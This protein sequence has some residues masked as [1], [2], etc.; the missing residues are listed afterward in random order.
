MRTDWSGR[1]WR[2]RKDAETLLKKIQIEKVMGSNPNSWNN[3]FKPWSLCKSVQLYPLAIEVVQFTHESTLCIQ[4]T[5]GGVVSTNLG[6]FTPYE[7]TWYGPWIWLDGLL[8]LPAEV[9][10][11]TCGRLDGKAIKENTQGSVGDDL[12]RKDTFSRRRN[13][14]KIQTGFSYFVSTIFFLDWTHVHVNKKQGKS[15]FLAGPR[16]WG[17]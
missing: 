5:S 14:R 7:H 3:F 15:F 16:S 12:Y 4:I 17:L 9:T 11:L 2:S 6:L 8:L 1:I 13:Q 10:A